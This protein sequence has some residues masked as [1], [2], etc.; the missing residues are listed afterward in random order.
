MASAQSDS[1]SA[2]SAQSDDDDQSQELM[3]V[4]LAKQVKTRLK[5]TTKRAQE[6]TEKMFDADIYSQEALGLPDPKITE[7][8]A[9]LGLGL[10][11]QSSFESWCVSKRT[12]A[13]TVAAS[14]PIMRPVD[15][16]PPHAGGG[17]VVRPIGKVP[18]KVPIAGSEEFG[19]P[20]PTE[21]P[22]FWA[23]NLARE[24]PVAKDKTMKIWLEYAN[25]KFLGEPSEFKAACLKR[26]DFGPHLEVFDRVFGETFDV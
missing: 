14:S 8:A 9:L 2:H 7:L 12:Y 26:G 17:S 21:F 24:K 20:G 15:G 10:G 16:R 11:A 13:A 3:F 22:K 1:A 25:T 18:M 23:V 6:I 19:K 4:E 5:V